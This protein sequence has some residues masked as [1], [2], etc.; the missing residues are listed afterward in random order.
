MN[1]FSVAPAEK[2]PSRN[3]R[4]TEP[5]SGESLFPGSQPVC[6]PVNSHFSNAPHLASPELLNRRFASLEAEKAELRLKAVAR[7]PADVAVHQIQNRLV[8]LNKRQQEVEHEIAAEAARAKLQPQ[9][10][11]ECDACEGIARKFELLEN[12]H[13][14]D[15]S[16]FREKAESMST[17]LVAALASLE[18]LKEA[19]KN[20][21]E[22]QQELEKKLVAEFEAVQVMR[23]E[24]SR[25]L[26]EWREGTESEQQEFK[27]ELE[28]LKTLVESV[29]ADGQRVATSFQDLNL[30]YKTVGEA[31]VKAMKQIDGLKKQ[32]ALVA[33]GQKEAQKIASAAEA[34]LA[35]VE[36]T[37]K[38]LQQKVSGVTDVDELAENIKAQSASIG[39]LKSAVDR[40]GV[41]QQE[42]DLKE[43]KA[44]TL[45]SKVNSEAA[46]VRDFIAD[47]KMQRMAKEAGQAEQ[48]V[49]GLD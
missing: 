8:E 40:V 22:N 24:V 41:R 14:Q 16:R 9:L 38:E 31:A 36:Q 48:R 5:I 19:E 49:D 43:Q 26:K 23:E 15:G 30:K 32:I 7:V 4:P 3:K 27:R 46:L 1:P 29:T 47:Q 10:R 17:E 13:K 20:N 25:K 44:A 21:R 12:H 18:K 28:N 42:F 33:E 37:V 2:W 6:S 35:E 34:K 45:I 39:N 11:V